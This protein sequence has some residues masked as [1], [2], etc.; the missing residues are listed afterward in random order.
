MV[1]VV[2]EEEQEEEGGEEEVVEE[3]SQEYSEFSLHVYILST[4]V[5]EH[6]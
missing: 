1:E 6:C 5:R 3:D 2:E 4:H